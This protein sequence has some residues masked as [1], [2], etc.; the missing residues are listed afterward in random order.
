MLIVAEDENHGVGYEGKIQWELPDEM[1]HFAVTTRG[2]TVIVGRKTYETF[3]PPYQPL[4]K[5]YNIILTRNASYQPPNANDK[6]YICTDYEDTIVLA[7]EL[8]SENDIFIIGGPELYALALNHPTLKVDRLYITTV[9]A[10]FPADAFFPGID[11]PLNWREKTLE[12]HPADE[13]HAYAYTVK[14]YDRLDFIM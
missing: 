11:D 14:Q 7:K 4:P 10:T 9:H 5:R 3:T 8:S 12:D 13:R 1:K 6:T 2:H